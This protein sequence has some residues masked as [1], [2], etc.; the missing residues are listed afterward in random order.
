MK[1]VRLGKSGLTVSKTAIGT[2]PLQRLSEDAAVSLV[3]KAYA[4]GITFYDTADNYSN[5]EL[6]LGLALEPVRHAVVIATKVSVHGY[7]AAK[8]A[9]EQSL[10]NLRTDYIDLV[11]LHNPPAMPQ[12]S[13]NNDAYA[14]LRDAWQKGYIRAI[15]FT[16]HNQDLAEEAARS[17]LFSTIQYPLNYLSSD[18][19]DS[20]I[21]ACSDCNIG[22]IAMKPFAGGMIRDAEL[23]FAYFRS[24]EAVVPIYGIQRLSE[25]QVLLELEANPPVMDALMQ[26]RIRQNQKLLQPLFCRGCDRCASACP[27]GIRPGYMGR[28]GDFLY[29]NRTDLYLTAAWHQEVEKITSCTQ[30]GRCVQ[31]CPNGCDLRKKMQESR[32]VFLDHWQRRQFKKLE[33][34]GP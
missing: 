11:Q 9:I 17:S 13:D 28:I 22:I 5:S 31:I 2:V 7:D 26:Q 8:K 10:C 23:T 1:Y 27:Q 30:C 24:R 4:G 33:I 20:W 19:D 14:A 29:R 32:A 12:N 34:N 3:R 25:L 15:G 18:R 6:R 16:T 21:R